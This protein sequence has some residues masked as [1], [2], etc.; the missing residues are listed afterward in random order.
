MAWHAANEPMMSHTRRALTTAGAISCLLSQHGAVR[1]DAVRHLADNGKPYLQIPAAP[2]AG[3]NYPYILF[4]PPEF[5]ARCLPYLIVEPNNGGLAPDGAQLTAAINLAVRVATHVS[6]GNQMAEHFGAPLLVPA[7]PRPPIGA[8]SD[9]DTHSLSRAALTTSGKLHRIDL[10]L[11]A[12][13][14]DAQ[15]RIQARGYAMNPKI[16]MT[17]YSGSGLFT[18]RFVFLHPNLIE[19]AAFG[20]LNSF[21]TLPVTQ[22]QGHPLEYPVG[23]AD[24]TKITGQQFDPSTYN[25]VPQF[26]FQGENDSNDAIQNDDEYTAPERDL[27][28][29]L[30]GKKMQPDRWEAVQAVYKTTPAAI[31]FKTYTDIGHGLDQRAF[32]KVADLFAKATSKTSQCHR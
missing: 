12:M 1:A 17:G 11:I 5:P 22:W 26:A 9:L 10:Q 32:E 21:I 3:F 16:L 4:K 25:A 28:W 20:G 18:S 6:L 31:E 27:I 13:V 15:R 24:Y 30:F 7:F 23:L 2:Q 8:D 19:A 29:L 14:T